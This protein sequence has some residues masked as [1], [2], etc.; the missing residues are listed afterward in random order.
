MALEFLSVGHVSWDITPRDRARRIPG[1]ASAFAAV[2]ARAL[3]IES[4]AVVTSA[5]GD[6]PIDDVVAEGSVRLVPAASTTTFE[7]RHDRHGRRHQRLEARAA[8]LRLDDIPDDWRDPRVLF[9]GPLAQELPADCLDWFTPQVSCVVPQ[10]WCRRWTEPL[11]SDVNVCSAPPAG[12]ADGWDVCV[13][14]EH[15]TTADSLDAWKQVA[16]VLVVTRGAQG[17]ELH[18]R[19]ELDPILVAPVTS[20]SVAEVGAET[21]GAGDV[22]AAVMAICI[23]RGLDTFESAESASYWAALS[24]T[25]P[26]WLGIW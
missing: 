15:E 12:F 8:E 7:N 4:V 24:T 6:Y 3:G 23:A 26:G 9:V 22:F 16:E 11:P 14:S 25:E 5:A 2:T 20:D 19:G 1:G 10:G 17:A 13:V 18:R 21:T